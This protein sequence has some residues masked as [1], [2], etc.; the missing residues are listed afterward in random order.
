MTKKITTVAIAATIKLADLIETN[1]EKLW[2]LYNSWFHMRVASQPI[3][4]SALPMGFGQWLELVSKLTETVCSELVRE[5]DQAHR[6]FFQETA[7]I[8]V[9]VEVMGNGTKAH[10]W[11]ASCRPMIVP[12]SLFC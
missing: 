6:F 11:E 7:N 3:N 4:A 8:R 12:H 9:H 1:P 10:P 5:H 2:P